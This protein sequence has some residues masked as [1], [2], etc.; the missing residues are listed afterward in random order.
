MDVGGYDYFEEQHITKTKA[1]L[2][3]QNI[4]DCFL[5]LLSSNTKKLD[6]GY[7]TKYHAYEVTEIT[8]RK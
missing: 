2:Q 5:D 4:P 6:F 7:D 1:L 8:I 3:L